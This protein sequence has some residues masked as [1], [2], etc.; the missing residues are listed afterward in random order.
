MGFNSAFKGL[1]EILDRSARTGLIWLRKGTSGG[2][3]WTRSW[4]FGVHKMREIS[5]LASNSLHCHRVMQTKTMKTI[6]YLKMS[7][8]I[9]KS[10]RR[11]FVRECLLSVGT[12]SFVFHCAIQK[13][14]GIPN[15]NSAC[16]FLL[17]VKLGRLHW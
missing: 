8:A 14:K 2:L 10:T 17:G 11:D 12:E 15:Y 7:V 1:K 3:L 6:L 13:F 16:C 5:Q 9:Y 4:T